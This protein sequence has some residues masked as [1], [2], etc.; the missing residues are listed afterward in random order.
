MEFDD[1]KAQTPVPYW[2]E[3]GSQLQFDDGKPTQT[4]VRYPI[5]PKVVANL[6]LMM[7]KPRK[8]QYPIGLKVLAV[9]NCS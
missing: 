8:A 6:S 9:A 1:G 3:G 4:P 7:E 2:P 5:G